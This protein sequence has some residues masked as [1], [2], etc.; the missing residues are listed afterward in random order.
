MPTNKDLSCDAIVI[1]TGIG[2]SSFA[3]GLSQQGLSVTVIDRGES[4]RHDTRDLSPVHVYRFGEKPYIGGLSKFYGASMYRLRELDFLPVEM[5]VGISPGWPISY[6]DLEPYYG[7]AERLYKVHGS[8]QQ[9]ATEPPRSTPWPHDPIPHQG[10]V[11]DL[12][13][14]LT[15]RAGVQVSYIPRALDY[16]PIRGGRCVLCRHCDAYFCPRDAKVDSE[17]GALR[18]AIG[19]GLVH[20]LPGTTCQRILTSPNGRRAV[21]V[22][23]KRN[24]DEFTIHAR[25]VAVSCGIMGT[26]VMLWQS[27]NDHHPNGLANGSGTLG[28]NFTAHTQGWLFALKPGVQRTPFHQKTFAIHAFYESAPDWPYPTGVIQAAGYIEPLGMSRRYRPFAAALLHNSFQMFAMTEGVPGPETGFQLSDSGATLM[29]PPRQNIKTFRTLRRHAKRLLRAAG[30]PVFAPGVYDTRWHGVGTARMGTDP[31]TSVIDPNCQAHDVEGLYVVD[32]S[33]L[34]SPG[35]V[36]TGLTIAAN[37]LRIADHIGG[38]SAL[39]AVPASL[40]AAG[41]PSIAAPGRAT[42][43][44]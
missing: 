16:D 12:V 40:S 24:G 43:Q 11:K 25:V 17:I 13:E 42:V 29:N 10:P 9:D 38:Q 15:N 2:G 33:A 21:G 18:P 30:Y 26:P 23:V 32:A 28:R 3:Y 22:R 8:S 27:R 34:V 44:S 20:L 19:T 39:S 41:I 36:N 4:I 1:G 14:R 37:A 6:R 35:A 7:A 31:A 5:E